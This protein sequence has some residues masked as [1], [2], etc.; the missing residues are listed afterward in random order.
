MLLAPFLLAA[1]A[2]A[3]HFQVQ[4]LMVEGEVASVIA[5]DLD[6]D[7]R[8]DLVAVYKTGLPPYQK[9]SFAI[10]WNRNGIFAPRPD[11]MLAVDEAE[12][13]AYDAGSVGPGPAEDLLLVT[14][15]GVNAKS[16]PGRVPAPPRKLVEHPTL[17]HQPIN[18]ELPRVKLIYDLA[19]PGSRDLLVPAL[20]SLAVFR[21]TGDHYDKAAELEVDMEVSGGPKRNEGI[22]VR[23][24]FPALNVMDTDGDGLRDIIATQEDRI[25]IYRQSPGFSFHP[26]PDFSRDF[27]VRTP[28]DHRERGTS[29]TTLVADVDGDGFADL[30]VRKQVFEGVTS[31]RNTIYLFFG[32]KDGFSAKPAEVLES[33]GV[34]LFQTQLVDLNG[35][36]RPDLVVPYTSFG[37]FALIRM[38]TAK[39]AKVDF[40]IYPFDPKTRKFTPE[41]ASDRELKFHIPLSGDSDLQAISLTA[42]VTGDGK[43]DLIFGSSDEELE[44]YPA[45]G[46]GEFA[47][48]AAETVEVRAAG[49]LDAVDLDGKGRSDLILYYP[50]TR[51]HRSEIVVL[52]NRGG[53]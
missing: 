38:L 33:E 37:V 4:A 20:G 1:A 5:A 27:A 21:R 45:L 29:A 51:G 40:Q 23:Y 8:K 30:I 10:F 12:A 13:C 50:K 53:W 49:V 19:G 36:G 2:A 39:T 14:P 44:I 9:R 17:F 34:S 52:I 25:A 18:G 43:P 28:A 6:G 26:Q 22:E 41:P 11:L 47:S 3:P 46:G 32:R 24:G 42:D 35:D 48:S 16:F 15:R 31:A 7:G